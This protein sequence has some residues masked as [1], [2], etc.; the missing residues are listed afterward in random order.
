MNPLRPHKSRHNSNYLYLLPAFIF[1]ILFILYPLSDTV[2]T[3]FTQWSGIGEKTWVGLEN[4]KNNLSDKKI[5]SS[6]KHSFILIIFYSFFPIIIGLGI[7]GMM[8]R[9][10]VKGMAI[11]RAILFL[12]QI[13]S[14]IGKKSTDYLLIR[15][16]HCAPRLFAARQSPVHRSQ[17]HCRLRQ[18][19][20]KDNAGGGAI[21]EKIG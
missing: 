21:Q 1:Y 15:C 5:T 2:Y 9:I 7:A 8:V 14:M 4:Y 19:G 12:P 13:L 11:Y 17:R 10:K 20:E 3:S 16:R 6:I 18:F